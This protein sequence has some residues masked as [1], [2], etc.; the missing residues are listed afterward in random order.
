M[1][2][3]PE[4][5][6]RIY[7]EEKARIEARDRIRAEQDHK[8]GSGCFPVVA[9]LVVVLIGLWIVGSV[10]NN[11]PGLG[12]TLTAGET[13]RLVCSGNDASDVVALGVT[14][15]DCDAL[16]EAQT[17]HDKY[18]I[19]E[20]LLTRR[21]YAIPCGTRVLV[22]DEGFTR[23]KVRIVDGEHVGLAGWIVHGAAR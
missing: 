15:D 13:G 19:R 21:V 8:F 5:R 14:K 2:L 11:K 18:G 3:P 6:Q 20:L 22:L 10:M 9:V 17:A 7:A 1:D 16:V 4:E 23:D 12:P